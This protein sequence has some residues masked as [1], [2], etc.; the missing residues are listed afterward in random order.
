MTKP[1]GGF[2]FIPVCVGVGGGGVGDGEG[3]VFASFAKLSSNFQQYTTI[4]QRIETT[5]A[6]DVV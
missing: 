2:N 6:I 5:E 4:I 3:S 1:R